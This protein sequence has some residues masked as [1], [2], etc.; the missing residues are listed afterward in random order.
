MPSAENASLVAHVDCAGGG[1]VWADRDRLYVGHMEPSAGTSIFDISDPRAPVLLRQTQMP[2]GWRSHKVRAVGDIMV[3]NH[4][5]VPHITLGPDGTLV[6]NLE[7]L[8]GTGP[9]GFS[10]GLSRSPR[11]MSR[12]PTPTG[13]PSPSSPA[14][15]SPPS[16]SRER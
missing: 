6:A 2:D 15:I 8:P 16:D 14:V 1:Q 11:S 9:S 13:R 10:G 12:A 3:V 5:R 4:E 7:G